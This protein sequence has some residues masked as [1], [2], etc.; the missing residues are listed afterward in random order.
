MNVI[1]LLDDYTGMVCGTIIPDGKVPMTK[2]QKAVQK[3]YDEYCTTNGDDEVDIDDYISYHNSTSTI[4]IKQIKC[5]L[6]SRNY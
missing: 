2:F 3:S 4:K 5:K 6:I 1:E